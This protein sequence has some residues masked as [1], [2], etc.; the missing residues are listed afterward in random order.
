MKNIKMNACIPFAWI[1]PLLTFCHICNLFKYGS[2]LMKIIPHAPLLRI[3][4][5]SYI[6]AIALSHLTYS[7][8]SISSSY[9]SFLKYPKNDL[10]SFLKKIVSNQGSHT[11]PISKREV[12]NFSLNNLFVYPMFPRLFINLFSGKAVEK[13]FPQVLFCQNH[14]AMEGYCDNRGEETEFPITSV[15]S[16]LPMKISRMKL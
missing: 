6:C 3:R 10:W 5:F 9:S 12:P 15:E 11:W 8:V 4:I 2:D 1:H 7:R 13:Q 14:S 16:A